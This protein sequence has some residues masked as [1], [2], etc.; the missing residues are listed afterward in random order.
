[1]TQWHKVL[2]AM[3]FSVG[4]TLVSMLAMAIL[5]GEHIPWPFWAFAA[6]CPAIISGPVTYI[7]ANQ[8]EVNRRLNQQL[9][10]TQA[11]LRAQADIDHLTGTL[12]RAAFYRQASDYADDAPA[13]VLLADIDHF[14]AINDLH[15]HAAGDHA[16]RLV[17]RTLQAALRPNDLLGRVGG[18]EFAVLLAA[19]PEELGIVI[20]ERARS[21]IAGLE[22]ATAD[23]TPVVLSISI[24]VAPLEAG[25]SLEQALA[26]AD[27]AMYAAK[28][29]GRNR[30]RAAG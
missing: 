19:M 22:V 11:V 14:K 18:E 28:R 1:M 26:Q 4:V 15:G 5:T 10:A 2:I 9:M 3:G 8:A 12:N 13:C 25:D 17:A 23:G 21:A 6:V 29:G 30:V 7:L 24:G 16:L 20:A 27:A